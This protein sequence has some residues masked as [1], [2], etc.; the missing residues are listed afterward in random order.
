MMR[1]LRLCDKG[2]PGGGGGKMG[3][4]EGW[5]GR[6]SPQCARKRLSE[7]ILEG[8]GKGRGEWNDLEKPREAVAAGQIRVRVDS[9]KKRE[10]SRGI[11]GGEGDA[12]HSKKG[13]GGSDEG[14]DNGG[15]GRAME[16]GV[17]FVAEGAGG[18]AERAAS[19]M[20]GTV[21]SGV[22]GEVMVSG[23]VAALDAEAKEGEGGMMGEDG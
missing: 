14:V 5:G 18:G 7:P 17:E 20:V 16:E 4:K 13:P 1:E 11:K 15:Q 22:G 23:E 12:M 10:D 21:L 6:R 19:K 2:V 8:E 3:R 9:K